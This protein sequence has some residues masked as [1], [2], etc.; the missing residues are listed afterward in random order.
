MPIKLQRP[1]SY[2]KLAII[3]G[4]LLIGIFL[5]WENFRGQLAYPS[6]AT[7]ASLVVLIILIRTRII[8]FQKNENESDRTSIWV[9]LS[10]FTKG[11]AC[12]VGGIV[13]VV[14]ALRLVSD[15]PIGVAIILIPLV[16]LTLMGVFFL[17]RGFFRNLQ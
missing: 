4:C 3:L 12:M 6:L 9:S 13:W 16:I 1:R 2:W 5:T 7:L 11:A 14:L 17:T 10:D 8:E 15:T